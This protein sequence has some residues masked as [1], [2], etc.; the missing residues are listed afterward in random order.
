M[1]KNR[2]QVCELYLSIIKII[3]STDSRNNTARRI[4]TV[5]ETLTALR[6]Q[7]LTSL[8]VDEERLL[9]CQFEFRN[10]LDDELSLM[11]R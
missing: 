7:H 10:D 1:N 2:Q 11:G 9:L 8:Y 5:L 6:K 4:K 3:T